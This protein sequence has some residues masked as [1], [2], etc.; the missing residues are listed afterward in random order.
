MDVIGPIEPAASNGHR[1]IL[2]A[3]A[4][5][6]KWVEASSYKSVTKK[7]VVDLV[8]N[9]IICRFRIPESIITDDGANLNSDLMREIFKKFKITHRNSTPYRP[10]MNGAVEAA[11]KNIKRILRKMIDNYRHW[12]EKLPLAFGFR[13][14]VRTSTGATPYLLVYGTEAVLPAEVEIPS[15]RIIQEAE[16][17]DAKWIQN[18]NEQLM[19]IDEKRMNAVC[20]GQLYQNRMAKAFNKKVRPRQFK[21]G[22]LV[23]KRIFP[24]Q[25]EAKGKFAPNWQGSYMVHRVLTGGALILAEMDGEVWPK[26]INADAVKRYYL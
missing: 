16:L 23:L 11:N 10:Q 22:Q 4:Y 8:R 21:S 5:F 12:H 3:I 6:T 13:T 17:S 1:F 7:V 25:N 14:T 9:N 26:A 20:H 15:L 19:L 24:H 2:V 18:Q